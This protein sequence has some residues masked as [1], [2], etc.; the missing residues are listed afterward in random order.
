VSTF[1]IRVEGLGKCFRQTVPRQ[2]TLAGRLRRR[3]KDEASASELWALR[4][5]S[6]SLAPGELLGVSGPNGAGK[7]TLL[8]LLAGI[9]RPTEGRVQT[10]GRVNTFFQI[11]AGIERELSLRD[12]IEISGTLMGLRRKAIRQCMD[13]IL[14]FAGLVEKADVRMAELSSGQVARA[15]FATA[16]HADLDVMLVDELLAVGDAAFQAKCL[17]TFAR[18]RADGR[19]LIVTSHDQELLARMASSRLHL[20]VG[21]MQ[22]EVRDGA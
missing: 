19:S 9:L 15:A 6:F 21:R 13:E 22:E 3:W 5:V 7:S 12:N 11:G 8:R 20:S 18:M 14:D 17:Q 2:L 10:R 1:A 4:D 16:V